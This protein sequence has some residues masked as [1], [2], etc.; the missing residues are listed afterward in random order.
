MVE[1]YFEEGKDGVIAT[2]KSVASSVIKGTEDFVNASDEFYGYLAKVLRDEIKKESK[3]IVLLKDLSELVRINS[4]SIKTQK[5]EPKGKK[6]S[7]IDRVKMKA[8]GEQTV[9]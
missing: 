1:Q 8:N 6:A 4:Q 5:E 2:G 7:P 9:V 3:D